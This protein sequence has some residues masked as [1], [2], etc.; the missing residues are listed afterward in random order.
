MQTYRDVILDPGGGAIPGAAVEV[1]RRGSGSLAP[2]FDAGTGLPAPNPVVTDQDGEFSFAAANGAY[3]M[4]VSHRSFNGGAPKNVDISI[5]DPDDVFGE[6]GRLS[7]ENLPFRVLLASSAEQMGSPGARNGDVLFR[8][9]TRRKYARVGG[10]WMSM[11]PVTSVAGKVG[12]VVI[13]PGDV[14]GLGD[15]VA[16]AT[17]I[18]DE[19][20]SA[21]Y[22]IA[23]H[24]GNI[25]LRPA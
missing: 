17:V 5:I 24:D 11:D 22:R 3:V 15:A 7:V 1:R 13:V 18:I 6:D 19:V 23:S 2:L 16:E 4:T 9:D 12:D 25:V 14:V 8:T 21:R 10:S 20:T